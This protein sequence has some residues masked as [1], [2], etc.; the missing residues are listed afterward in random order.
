MHESAS[1]SDVLK[2]MDIWCS[3]QRICEVDIRDFIKLTNECPPELNGY[4]Q[5]RYTCLQGTT[6]PLFQHKAFIYD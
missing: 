2:Y 1:F 3:G 4:L 6:I 5:A